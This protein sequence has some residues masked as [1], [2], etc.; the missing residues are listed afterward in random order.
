MKYCEQCG[1]QLIDSAVFCQKCGAKQK[2][3]VNAPVE[4]A[5]SAI[6]TTKQKPKKKKKL[7]AII[8]AAVAVLLVAAIVLTGVLI[9]P[10][11]L[12][13]DILLKTD[14]ELGYV[15][16]MT[17]EQFIDR[18]NNA[19]STLQLDN[20]RMITQTDF[21]NMI[22]DDDYERYGVSQ[23]SGKAHG[24]IRLFFDDHSRI[25]NIEILLDGFIDDRKMEILPILKTVNPDCTK[26]EVENMY[27]N[28]ING[29]T[30]YTDDKYIS[31]K[32][33]YNNCVL[34]E[35]QGI[36]T[37][38]EHRFSL[39]ILPIKESKIDDVSEITKKDLQEY[40]KDLYQ[41]YENIF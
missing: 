3:I 12:H 25:F 9:V 21:D 2:T 27:D 18:Y 35:Y 23:I 5:A 38:L 7:L 37:E 32:H 1:A 39:N 41:F 29:N 11:L 10:R 16:D 24:Y 6:E 28:I 13:K 30:V 36:N 22:L 33:Y 15:F 26:K 19:V 14:T 20:E 40:Q 8:I 31:L 4:P 17:F 34:Y